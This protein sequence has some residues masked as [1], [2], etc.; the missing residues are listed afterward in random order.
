MQKKYCYIQALPDLR[1]SYFP[2]GPMQVE[3]Y[4][5]WNK[6]YCV[7]TQLAVQLNSS[8]NTLENNRQYYDVP[9][10]CMIAQK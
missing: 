8:S 4:A 5:I 1:N 2:E 3:F 9:A 10:V 7:C 6:V